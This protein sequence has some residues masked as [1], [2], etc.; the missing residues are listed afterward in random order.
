MPFPVFSIP[1]ESVEIVFSAKSR[2]KKLEKE[3]GG[4]EVRPAASAVR[5]MMCVVSDCRLIDRR[6]TKLQFPKTSPVLSLLLTGPAIFISIA[7]T[8]CPVSTSPPQLALWYVSIILDLRILNLTQSRSSIGAC[9]QNPQVFNQS[10]SYRDVSWPG[11]QQGRQVP[12]PGMQGQKLKQQSD[13]RY[14][15]IPSL[16]Q[17]MPRR[18]ITYEIP[19]E[20]QV[21]QC[22]VLVSFFSTVRA[23]Q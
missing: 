10:P 9:P 3:A 23:C 19:R 18:H 11:N 14:D 21:S 7:K 5:C 2:G 6:R 17:S 12:D 1:S 13:C 8:C 16:D 15:G 4:A 20:R 22:T